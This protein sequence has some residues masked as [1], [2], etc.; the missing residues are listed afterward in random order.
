MKKIIGL[1]FVFSMGC[2][3]LFAQVQKLKNQPY[4]D[5]RLFH[6]G[7][8]LGFHTQDLILTH[9]GFVNDNGEVWFAEIPSYSPGFN[10]GIIGDV[11]VNR[12]MNLRLSPTLQL[13]NKN[14]VFKE[15]ASGEEFKTNLRNN[16]ISVPLHVKLA[17]DRINN[18]RPYF[19]VG[20]YG[21]LELAAKK[22][23]PILLK[24]IDYGIEIGFGCDFYLPLFKLSPELKFG[25][26]LVNALP[27]D[28]SD[29][30]E[31]DLQKYPRAL[32]KATHRTITLS[33]NFE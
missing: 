23:R 20:G 19:L 26:G 10:V 32:S 7:F 25:F 5:Q 1:F 13:G 2:S 4:A 33:F 31:E 6:L 12:F 16:Y 27:K 15:Q 14:F 3:P 21:R 28:R 18:Y 24:P 11:Y 8:T 30:I 22:N 9:S 17:A 29:L